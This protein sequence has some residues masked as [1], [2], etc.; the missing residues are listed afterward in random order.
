MAEN[1]PAAD[2]LE[3]RAAA[4]AKL[5]GVPVEC[6][7]A[8][9]VPKWVADAL[10][11]EFPFDRFLDD[12]RRRPPMWL[13]AQ[14][15]DPGK[16]AEELA[17]A[18]LSVRRHER[19][20][21]ALRVEDPR[22]NLHTLE[23]FRRGDFEVQDLASQ[24]IGLTAA[25]RP[26]EQWLDA[27]AG[28]GGKSLQLADLMKRR[29]TVVACDVRS[30]KLDD[31]RLRARRAGFPNIITRE[32]D[33]KPFRGKQAGRFDGVLVDAPCSCSGVWRRNPDGRWTLRPE[34]PAETADLQLKILSAAAPAVRPGV[35]WSTR[36]ARSSRRKTQWWWRNFSPPIRSSRWNR[37]STRS[38]GSPVP[39]NFRSAVSTGTATRCSWRGCAGKRRRSG[40]EVPHRPG[41]A[42]DSPEHRHHRPP[43]R[44]DRNGAA[45]GQ[46]ARF[47]A[48]G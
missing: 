41:R 40:E 36:P 47:F 30:Y 13:R 28:A 37:L 43:L 32:W 44:L 35:C 29:G 1:P 18:G 2:P 38:P 12:L 10:P 23:S 20:P 17:Q 3:G 21:T 15:D 4:L 31:L 42:G 45:P 33:G 11:P 6:R 24:C 7:L 46:T 5:Y 27:C 9:L 22:V 39:E 34:E 19:I 26:G 25:P 8:D 14:C 48:G 16:L